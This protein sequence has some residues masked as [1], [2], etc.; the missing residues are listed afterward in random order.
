MYLMKTKFFV[1]ILLIFA[2]LLSGCLG[3]GGDVTLVEPGSH[4]KIDYNGTELIMELNFWNIKE[5]NGSAKL[6]YHKNNYTIGFYANLSDIVMEEPQRYIQGYPEI[7]YGYKPWIGHGTNGKLPKRIKELGDIE[8]TLNYALWHE[9][10]LP[11]NL[12]METWITAEEKAR[13]AKEGDVELM[14]WLYSNSLVRP[15][16]SKIKTIN[17]PIVVND[18]LREAEWEVWLYCNALPWDLI[19]FRLKEPIKSGKVKLSVLPLI[20]TAKEVFEENS[21]RV[22]DF[23]ELYLE[24][25]EVGTEFGSPYKRSANFGWQIFEFEIR[26]KE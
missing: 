19:T 13:E 4:R 5:F 24:D 15:A 1:M 6:V 11:I 9:R 3:G 21:C 16:G 22:K 20:A 25:W 26:V 23:E 8:V 2:S 7:F 12:A 17:A 10:N 14:V 18:T